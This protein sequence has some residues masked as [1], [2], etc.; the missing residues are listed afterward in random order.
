[1]GSRWCWVLVLC[2]FAL[3]QVASLGRNLWIKVWASRYDRQESETPPNARAKAA[4]K[5]SSEIF[6]RLLN[7]VL[8]AK[9]VLFDRPLGQSTNHLSKDEGVVAVSGVLLDQCVPDR[10]VGGYGRRDHP[11]G[12]TGLAPIVVLAVNFLAYYYVTAVYINVARDLKHIE[13]VARSPLYG[14]EAMFTAQHDDLVDRLN[15]PYL[16]LWTSKQWLTLR[17]DVL[18]SIV[19]F[20]TAAFVLSKTGLIGAGAAGLVLTYAATFTDHMLWFVQIYAIIQQSLT[21]VERIK[22]SSAWTRHG[23]IRFHN[24]TARYAPHLEPPGERVAVVAL[25]RALDPH[26]DGGSISIDGIDIAD[27]SLPRLRGV[28]ITVVPQDA[29]LFDGSVHA[30]LDPLHQHDDAQLVAALRSLQHEHKPDW[31]DLNWLAAELSHGERQ[32]LCVG[33]GLLHGSLLLEIARARDGS[34]D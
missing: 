19:A 15:Q 5:A 3:Q 6:E 14:R 2:G 20:S 1:M 26:P 8:F 11:V 16:L 10:G 25:L 17:I 32:L 9:F 18:S 4:G 27:V 13:S 21:S 34:S 7:S 30:N 28:A 29:Q 12:A 22:V 24:F 33:R 31:A 23:A